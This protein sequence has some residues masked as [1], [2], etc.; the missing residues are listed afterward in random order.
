MK[1]HSTARSM[2]AGLIVSAAIVT[3]FG[4]FT[5]ATTSTAAATTSTAVLEQAT[6]TIKIAADTVKPVARVAR[7]LRTATAISPAAVRPATK[8]VRTAGYVS[9]KGDLAQARAILARLIAKYPILKGTTVSVG[10]TPGGY[11]AVCYY[12]SGRIVLSPNRTSSL[13]TIITHEAWHVIDWRDNGRI[14][15]GE[16]IPR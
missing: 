10:T 5:G 8:A 12:K 2:V 3:V 14:N 9:S 13:S 15:W 7:K 4:G 11:Q 6:P 16:N 1:Y